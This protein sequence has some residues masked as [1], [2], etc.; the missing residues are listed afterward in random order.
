M[1]Q[2]SVNAEEKS[3]SDIVPVTIGFG[4][5]NSPP[6]AILNGE[7]IVGG[8]IFDIVTELSDILDIDVNY[9]NMPRKRENS[10][11]ENGTVDIVL[12][13]NPKWHSVKGGRWSI[14]LFEEKNV[15][16]VK[17]ATDD[18]ENVADL[19]NKT[20]GATRGYI[21][22]LLTKAFTEKKINRSDVRSMKL[23]FERLD[24]NWIDGFIGSDILIDY[25]LKNSTDADNFFV[26]SLLISE[27]RIHAIMSPHSPITIESLNS[28]LSTLKE[29]GVISAILSKYKISD[30][31]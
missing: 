15:I 11:I 5:H 25:Y 30:T 21:Y 9:L 18:F 31:Q 24:K 1:T 19:E 4:V 29:D 7:F 2:A 26:A 27:H 14:P 22:P 16:V 3:H 23:N 28:A 13:S 10:Y 6:Y 8:V 20:I 17:S 12:I